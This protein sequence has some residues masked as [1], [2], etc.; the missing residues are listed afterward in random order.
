MHSPMFSASGRPLM[1][2]ERGGSPKEGRRLPAKRGGRQLAWGSP[3]A[4]RTSDP[5]WSLNYDPLEPHNH[6]PT[7]ISSALLA[8]EFCSVQED[9]GREI[10]RV[11]RPAKSDL[12]SMLYD[13]SYVPTRARSGRR[14]TGLSLAA[15]TGRPGLAPTWHIGPSRV[16][17]GSCACTVP[18]QP[19]PEANPSRAPSSPN[20]R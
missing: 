6:P 16:P 5:R 14:T 9:L 12:F 11:F 13:T 20:L 17:K 18:G 4:G 7:G 3:S 19:P 15:A 1:G 10:A 8:P 2:R